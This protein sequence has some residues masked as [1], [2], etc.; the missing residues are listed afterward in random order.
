MKDNASD[1]PPKAM[2]LQEFQDWIPDE[3]AAVKYFEGTRWNG[4]PV[5]P[6]CK[7]E[8]VARIESGKP[9]PFRCRDCREHFS[10]KHGTVMQSSKIGVRTWLTAMYFMS[11]AKKGVSSC[12]MARQLGI[13]Q[14]TAW[15]LQQRIRESWNQERFLVDGEVEMD[16]TYIG[17]KEKNKHYSKRLHAGRG[18]VGKTM[19]VGLK[20]RNGKMFAVVAKAASKEVL[21]EIIDQRIAPTATLYTDEHRGYI[22]AP[23]KHHYAVKHSAGEYVNGNAS[24]NGVESFWALLKRGYYGTFHNMTV[25]H[26]PRYVDEFATRQNSLALTTEEQIKATLTGAVGR[27]MPY[28]KLIQ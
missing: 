5:C 22:G 17:G 24:T 14:D 10:V 12:Q 8:N 26:L 21:H 16:E 1:K 4:T 23:V 27:T 2:S 20:Q 28:K 18:G 11:V 3:A 25:K 19:V 15:F 13:K 7:S 6:H 9:M